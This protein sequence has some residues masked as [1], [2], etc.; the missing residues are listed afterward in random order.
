VGP[1]YT[2]L[3]DANVLYPAPLRD[4][5][6]RLAMEDIFLARWT[7]QIHEEWIR[8]LL[9]NRPDLKPADVYRTRDLMNAH[10]RD[11][12]VS[13]YEPLIDGLDLP[14]RDDRHVLAAA[15]KAQAQAII[16]YNLSDFPAEKLEPFGIEAVHPDDFIMYQFDLHEAA[17]CRAV[18]KQRAALRKPPQSIDQLLDTLGKQSLPKA[19]ARLRPFA[20]LL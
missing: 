10:V 20:Q 5:L 3:Y 8:N 19:V 18:R 2:V 14:D 17:V 1:S 7:D 16:T 12:L 4:L 11:C 15:I 13:G 9:A 6:M